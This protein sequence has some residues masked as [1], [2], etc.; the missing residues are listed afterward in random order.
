MSLNRLARAQGEPFFRHISM[1]VAQ[2]MFT[3]DTL[4][5][6]DSRYIN[7]TKSNIFCGKMTKYRI[8]ATDCSS[9]LPYICMSGK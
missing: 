5:D 3:A 6:Y 7:S 9:K 4:W 2:A 1:K 8:T